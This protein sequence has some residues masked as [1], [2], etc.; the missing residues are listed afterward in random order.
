[1]STGMTFVPGIVGGGVDSVRRS[2]YKNGVVEHVR[3]PAT[4]NSCIGERLG[5]KK[6]TTMP[7]LNFVITIRGVP[8]TITFGDVLTFCKVH[9]AFTAARAFVRQLSEKRYNES[10][11]VIMEIMLLVDQGALWPLIMWMSLGHLYDF[12]FA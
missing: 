7:T 8:F 1:M 5:T 10:L 12:V 3:Q 9:V 6:L 2:L 11:W 4:T